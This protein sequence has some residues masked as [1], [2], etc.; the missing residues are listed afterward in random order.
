MAGFLSDPRDTFTTPIGPAIIQSFFRDGSSASSSGTSPYTPPSSASDIPP[1]EGYSPNPGAGEVST[2]DFM[3]YLNGLITNQGLE[4]MLNRQFNSAEAERNRQ[5]QSQEAKIQ[6]DWYES[7]SNSAYTRA[8]ADMKAAG[9][10]PILAYQ[11]GGAA[12]AGTGI[13]A[14]SAASYTATGGDTLSSLLSAAA[15]LVGS[16][17]SASNGKADNAIKLLKLF[18]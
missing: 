12:T 8:V 11:N 6:R 15:D 1:S 13:A 17:T 2:T 18:I 16:I 10:N 9:I 14:G 4:N 7:M 3:D 5:F